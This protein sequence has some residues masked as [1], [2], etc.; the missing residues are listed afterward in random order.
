MKYTAEESSE[1]SMHEV[2]LLYTILRKLGVWDEY[3]R[4]RM[5]NEHTF[6]NADGYYDKAKPLCGKLVM[7]DAWIKEMR[8]FTQ[9]S[10]P[11]V[12]HI[13]Y[14]SKGWLTMNFSQELVS[15]IWMSSARGFAFWSNVC[16]KLSTN[17]LIRY[18]GKTC[19]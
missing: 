2:Y 3:L 1:M 15:F 19:H 11:S 18:L 7:M 17:P 12:F 8:Y 14:G 5:G 6:I 13:N 9:A 10:K 4:E 16:N